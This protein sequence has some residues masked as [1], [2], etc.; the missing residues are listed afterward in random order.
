MSNWI[1]E[2]KNSIPEHASDIADS[3]D[4][5]FN[6]NELDE[7]D[8]HACALA[9]AISAGNGELAFEIS[10]NGPLLGSAEREAAKT[11]AALMGMNNVYYSFSDSEA[12][13]EIKS[14]APNLKTDS[15]GAF[16]GVSEKQ[17]EMYCLACSIANRSDYCVKL[18]SQALKGL[19]LN[20]VQLQSIARIVAVVSA[21][22]KI[23]I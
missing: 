12:G 2:I 5:V 16:G 23:A 3:L 21:I 20:T 10:M 17:F 7:I 22:G 11:A 13:H 1:D 14:L 15:Y 6:D 9:S 4:L 18:H 8:A 19:G